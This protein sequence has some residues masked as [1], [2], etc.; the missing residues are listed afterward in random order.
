MSNIWH[1]ISPSRIKENDFIAVIE[2]EK[3][4]KNKYEL[5]KE[6]GHIILDIIMMYFHLS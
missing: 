1:D 3:G 2:I 6:T 5:D 4:S